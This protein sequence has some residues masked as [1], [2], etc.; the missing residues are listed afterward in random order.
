VSLLPVEPGALPVAVLVW[1]LLFGLGAYLLLTAQPV[2]EPKA[3]LGEMLR[4]L[5]V[6]ERVRGEA[7]GGPAR[8]MF[9]SRL[10][11]S[12]LRP[13]LDDA[14]RLLRAAL[15]RFGLGGG[16]ELERALRLVRP[17]VDPA[18]FFGE[19]VASGLVGLALTPTLNAFGVDPF[20]PWPLWVALAGGALG[21]LAPDWDLARRVAARRTRS[22][23][24]LAPLVDM[25]TIA[26]AAGLALEEALVR[27]A[28]E[29]RG[30]VADE[31]MR[32]S[33]EAALGQTT[34]VRA[35]EAMAE[36]NGVA[37]LASLVSQLR[38]SHEQGLPL[39]QTLT[40]QADAL[41]EKR[42]LR[43][44]EAGGRATAAMLLPVALFVLPVLF[45]VLLVPAF[46]Q[47]VGL[48]G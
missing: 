2:G 34:L 15:A 24:E 31:L 20:G 18:Q 3:D 1:P 9:A 28:R 37:E 47:I 21:F 44:L 41:R 12:M 48:G 40:V 23:M 17:G 16:A 13:A 38:A 46:V 33:R 43:I 19:K 6:D 11:E 42:R 29:G 10:L 22:L 27:V 4:R 45:V 36:R 32:A 5:D 7:G 35:L 39:V 26:V 30:V 8:P 14:G 25:L